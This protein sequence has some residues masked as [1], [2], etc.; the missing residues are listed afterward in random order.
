MDRTG[1]PEGPPAYRKS[2]R[3]NEETSN[4]RTKPVLAKGCSWLSSQK[5]CLSKMEAGGSFWA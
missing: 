2:F 4:Q 1:G 3:G 5:G